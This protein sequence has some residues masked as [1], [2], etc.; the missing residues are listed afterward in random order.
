[1][2]TTAFGKETPFFVSRNEVEFSAAHAEFF[3]LY[4][5]FEFRR[6]PRMFDLSG[7]LQDSVRLDPV[8]YL[9]RF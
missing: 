8:S 3:H 1:M 6:Q 2:K 4:R 5:L 9:A 7:R